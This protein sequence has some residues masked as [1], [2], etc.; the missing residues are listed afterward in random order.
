MAA[1]PV[2]RDRARTLR[3]LGI[4]TLRVRYEDFIADPERVIA[5]ILHTVGAGQPPQDLSHL[6]TG[7][8]FQGTRLIRTEVIALQ[9]ATPRNGRTS[10][11]KAV[12]Q[13]PWTTLLPR[14][15][16]LAGSGRANGTADA[17]RQ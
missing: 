16:P 5:D 3:R 14:L 15:R 9:G 8:P 7:L 6:R 10:A 1:S 4:P 2:I 11:V 12:L 17:A 13:A